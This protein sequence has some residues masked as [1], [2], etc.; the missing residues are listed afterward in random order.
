MKEN[1]FC[2]NSFK[3]FFLEKNFSKNISKILGKFFL[4]GFFGENSQ[5][6]PN[7]RV[8]D[9]V[10]SKFNLEM[11]WLVQIYQAEKILSNK[12]FISALYLMLF[13]TYIWIFFFDFSS[14]IIFFVF[15]VCKKEY[16]FCRVLSLTNSESQRSTFASDILRFFF[17][18]QV[19][20]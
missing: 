4:Q 14:E 15:C 18:F 1:F 2:W 20:N 19:L 10:S 5:N 11:E 9:I 12:S 3:A 13:C 6:S 17:F 7:Q 8:R 16:I